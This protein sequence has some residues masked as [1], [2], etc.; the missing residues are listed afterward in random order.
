MFNFFAKGEAKNQRKESL[1]GI[2]IGPIVVKIGSL[3]SSI[4]ERGKYNQW[5]FEDR[6][7]KKW[8]QVMK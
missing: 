1:K 5:T 6:K 4:K 7:I 8:A 3:F 2:T